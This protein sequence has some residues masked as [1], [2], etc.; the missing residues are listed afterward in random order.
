MSRA[1]T[2]IVCFA[3]FASPSLADGDFIPGNVDA[4]DAQARAFHEP[5]AVALQQP[6][7]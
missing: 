7:Q 3:I 1:L 4:L 2:S 6:G 5:E